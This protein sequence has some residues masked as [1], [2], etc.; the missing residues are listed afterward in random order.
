MTIIEGLICKREVYCAITGETILPPSAVTC[1]Q[2]LLQETCHFLHPQHRTVQ[3]ILLHRRH[4]ANW[5][6]RE[7]GGQTGARIYALIGGF[8][9][10]RILANCCVRMMIKTIV[11]EVIFVYSKQGNINKLASLEATLVGNSHE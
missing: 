11:G 5:V 10:Q 6:G 4:S 8:G 9:S 3:R 7:G 1:Y 2:I